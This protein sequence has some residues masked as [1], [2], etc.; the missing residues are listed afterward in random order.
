MSVALQ[1]REVSQ[2]RQYLTF[3]LN[4]QEFGIDILQVQEIKNFSRINTDPQLSRKHPRSHQPP[5][6]GYSIVNLR[7]SFGMPD[8]Q[9]ASYKVIIVV[10]VRAKFVGLVVDAVSDVLDVDSSEIESPEVISRD[11]ANAVISGIAKSGESLITIWILRT[12]SPND[13]RSRTALTKESENANEKLSRNQLLSGAAAFMLF[14]SALSM[15]TAYSSFSK[16]RHD[17]ELTHPLVDNKDFIADILPPPA[18]IVEA[19]LLVTQMLEV[20]DDTVRRDLESSSPLS[21]ELNLSIA[22]WDAKR[23]RI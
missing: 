1:E 2:S 15:Y 5:R 21:K 11:Q 17:G 7:R 8:A 14:F 23:R 6:H 20:S 12:L 9:E 3:L 22:K 16:L 4:E 18:Y 19:N 10:N 13:F